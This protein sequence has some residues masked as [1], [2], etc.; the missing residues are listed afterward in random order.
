MTQHKASELS[1]YTHSDGHAPSDRAANKLISSVV[2]NGNSPSR[3]KSR[4]LTGPSM[5]L[6]L[7]QN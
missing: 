7:S 5:K 3:L 6:S 2:L 1:T 4:H